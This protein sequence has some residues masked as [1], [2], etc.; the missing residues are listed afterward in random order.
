MPYNS[1]SLKFSV[2]QATSSA[3]EL[4]VI[5]SIP[6][7]ANAFVL[8]SGFSTNLPAFAN[9]QVVCVVEYA[10]STTNR[11][12]GCTGVGALAI[13]PMVY[14]V[15]WK[16]FFPY[17]NY[18]SSINCSKF[19]LLQI[20]TTTTI[21]SSSYAYYLGRGDS[22]LNYVKSSS[23][24]VVIGRNSTY[25]NYMTTFPS[26]NLVVLSSDFQEFLSQPESIYINNR[27]AGYTNK[28][29]N[30]VYVITQNLAFL[31]YIN[32]FTDIYC[33]VLIPQN[34]DIVNGYGT[35][36]LVA[37]TTPK[38]TL[39]ITTS[40]SQDWSDFVTNQNPLLSTVA[41]SATSTPGTSVLTS[42]SSQSLVFSMKA[43]YSTVTSFSSAAATSITN[44]WG[45]MIMM[46][47]AITLATSPALAI[48]ESSATQL[49]PTV[50]T[51]S[52]VGSY[53]LYT[54]ITLQGSISDALQT[55]F[56]TTA[57]KTSFGLYPFVVGTFSSI[58]ADANNLDIMIAT[59][60]GINGPQNKMTYNG[61]FL[62]NSFSYTGSAAGTTRVGF[63][64]YQSTTALDGSKVPTMLRVKG[65]ITNNATTLD[66]LVIFFDSLTP[67]FSNKHAGEVFCYS[68]DNSNPCR[69]YQ[70]PS[71][72]VTGY[73]LYN[74]Q[75]LSRFEI[76]LNTPGTA[77]N[78]LIP[79]T[80][81]SGQTA[82]NMYIAF[83]T[84]NST[85]GYKN[86]AYV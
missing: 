22:F 63:V 24:F 74:Y 86:I 46:S 69:Y 49:T 37:T 44:N 57:S 43:L 1:F 56:K 13:S 64:N 23:N 50:T 4:K 78:V 7:E 41:S 28:T 85:S 3:V 25:I 15:G 53:N 82:T 19:G 31:T 10:S 52:A 45:M 42:G 66:S 32:L 68:S 81:T 72:T 12:I 38:N 59:V 20:L 48:T 21:S 16:M 29:Y 8:P 9:K 70:G 83:Q 79:V 51:V 55:S 6:S 18:Q 33:A 61:F 35:L 40:N 73:E 65:T 71:S 27:P 77:F 60:D 84:V 62:I 36:P 67:F 47:P 39:T 80:F 30:D 2:S 76:S 14:Y 58:Y 26:I 54:M 11:Q 75:Q 34:T 5:I 17:D